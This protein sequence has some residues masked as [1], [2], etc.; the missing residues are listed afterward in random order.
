[1]VIELVHHADFGERE[2]ALQKSAGEQA[3]APGIKAV[4]AAHPGDA[5]CELRRGPDRRGHD[6]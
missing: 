1:M 3:D 2:F 5:I 6:G 4:E